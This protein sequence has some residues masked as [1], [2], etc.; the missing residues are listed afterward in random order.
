[1]AQNRMPLQPQVCVCSS[2]D[3]DD[4]GVCAAGVVSTVILKTSKIKFEKINRKK[5]TRKKQAF[6]RFTEYFSENGMEKGRG[7]VSDAAAA[8]LQTAG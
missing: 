5:S 7:R 6:T 8:G 4:C 3:A 2:V 1:M